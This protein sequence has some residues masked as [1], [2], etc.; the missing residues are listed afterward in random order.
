MKKRIANLLWLIVLLPTTVLC[1][2]VELPFDNAHYT[3]LKSNADAKLQAELV[4]T[5]QTDPK[6]SQLIS[7]KL[8][9][10][11][12]VD[13][14]NPLKPRFAQINGDHMMYAASL[15]KIAVLL[16]VEQ[17][18]E[19]GSLTMTPTL[20][21]LMSKMITVSNN[22]CTTELIDL[23]GMDKIAAVLQDD[24]Y[25]LYDESK[26][27]GLWVGKR[28]GAGGGR[29]PDPLKGLSHAA[30]ATQVCRFYYMLAY[31][32]LISC[33]RSTEMLEYLKDPQLHHK[34]VNVLDRVCPDAEIYRKSGSWR[35]Y[36]S[37]S[38]IVIGDE[39]RSY[40][41]VALVDDADGGQI[42]KDVISKVDE[43]LKPK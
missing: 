9:S 20:D 1:Q 10:I 17:A 42:V 11:G 18:L 5:F 4:S 16:A 21:Q 37:D 13:L 32:K 39:W 38:A 36:H 24:R 30:T 3:P 31:G 8:L 43:L 7:K 25:N 23:V 35:T 34:F 27:G 29:N 40:I 15:P 33:D 41:L 19:D 26:G 2:V 28:Y 14:S 6:M 22:S 12:V